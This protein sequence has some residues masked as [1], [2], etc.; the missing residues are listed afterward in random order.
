M[1]EPVYRFNSVIVRPPARSV[2]HGLRADDR[3]DPTFAGVAAEHA[4]Y[5]PALEKAAQGEDAEIAKACRVILNALDAG[6]ALEE[7][8]K[9][10]QK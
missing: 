4:A 8:K 1:A 7:L 9:N 5:V 3:G 10:A 6:P 2:V